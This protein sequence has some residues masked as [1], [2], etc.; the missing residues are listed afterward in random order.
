MNSPLFDRKHYPKGYTMSHNP[1]LH[2]TINVIY[3]NSPEN[4]D[5]ITKKINMIK[6]ILLENKNKQLFSDE[7]TRDINIIIR[8]MGFKQIN[9]LNYDDILLLLGRL[10]D[11]SRKEIDNLFKNEQYN[12]VSSKERISKYHRNYLSKNKYKAEETNNISKTGGRRTRKHSKK[13]RKTRRHRR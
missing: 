10:E 7:T 5:N 2:N 8:G 6:K 9:E 11:T 3:E 13:A 1:K 12:N 4:Y